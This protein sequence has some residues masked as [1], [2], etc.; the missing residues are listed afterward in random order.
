MP[1]R[2]PRGTRVDVRLQ[3]WVRR[4]SPTHKCWWLPLEVN[5]TT[6][7]DKAERLN[8]GCFCITLDRHALMETLNKEIGSRDF[9]QLL[10]ETYPTLFSNVPVFVPTAT[11]IEM[12]RVSMQW[13]PRRACQITVRRLCC[14]RRRL[15]D[16]TL[17]QSEP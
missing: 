3:E 2:E 8:R 6:G 1:L 16:W 17:A 13:K 5:V 15:P 12:S 11:L 4:N 9:A 7:G 14:G 10:S